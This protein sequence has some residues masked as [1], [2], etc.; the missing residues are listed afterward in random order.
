MLSS[1]EWLRLCR[2]GAELMATLRCLREMPAVATQQEIGSPHSG[3]SGPCWRCWLYQRTVSPKGESRYCAFC[4]AVNAKLW[5]VANLASGSV[6]I[7]GNL[8]RIPLQL[9]DTGARQ[10]NGRG[11]YYVHDENR[12]LLMMP[13]GELKLWLQELTLYHGLD[14]YG[15]LQI[16]PS[17]A[18]LPNLTMG[19]L[20]CLAVHHEADLA[21]NRL[22]VRFYSSP[23]HMIRPRIRD[24]EGLLTF[25]ISEFLSLLEMAEVFR[26][27]LKPW[28]R[29]ELLDLLRIGD[30]LQEP[31]YWGRFL[32]N[33]NQQAKDMLASWR[34]RQWPTN[35]IRLLY[36]LVDYAD[37]RQIT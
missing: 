20:L 32:G 17:K 3:L 14:L 22:R 9:L 6:V 7:W 1:F 31:F 11:D 26:T 8:N 33:L 27:I 36:E 5:G 28:E 37:V 23:F 19:D 12:F 30:P 10:R 34:I 4:H 21:M 15:L 24:R 2:S 25:E 16:F 29:K 18:T 35:R 13:R